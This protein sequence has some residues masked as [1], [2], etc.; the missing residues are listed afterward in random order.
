MT[1]E[2]RTGLPQPR[3]PQMTITDRAMLSAIEP[4]YISAYLRAN[5]YERATRVP[6]GWF[7]QYPGLKEPR[8]REIYVPDS[9]AI[10]GGHYHRAVSRALDDAAHCEGRNAL[11]VYWDVI[12]IKSGTQITDTVISAETLTE[13]QSVLTAVARGGAPDPGLAE[14]ARA[15]H[16]NL[17]W[18]TNGQHNPKDNREE[19]EE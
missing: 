17:N 7:W 15:L 5:D 11:D 9:D 18:P 12:A 1:A 16:E 14:R 19:E 3:L 10:L 6:T 2:L 13:V 4:K 8:E